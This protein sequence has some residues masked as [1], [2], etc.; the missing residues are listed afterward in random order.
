ML[1]CQRSFAGRHPGKFELPGGKLEP[2]ETLP[3]CLARE[4]REEL[5]IDAQVG[6][7]LWTTEHHYAADAAVQLSFFEIDS[8]R[9][10]IE[11]RVFAALLW[12]PLGQLAEL[13]F[14]EADRALVTWLD[15][16]YTAASSGR[17]R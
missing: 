10:E 16:H 4:L 5:G 8:Y 9:G 2:G 15:T 11:N 14:L 17:D 1:V 6:R 3:E 13:D 12:Q 7:L